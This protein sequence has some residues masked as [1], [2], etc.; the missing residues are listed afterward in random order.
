MVPGKP[1]ESLLVEM[2]SGDIPAMPHKEKRSDKR[3]GG[4]HPQMDRDRR[5]W[6]TELSLRDRRFEG[7][8]WWA[9]E[10]L[11]APKP[12]AMRSAWV[13]NP[14]DAFILAELEEHGLKPSLEADRRTL[15]RRLS[16]DL[17]GLPPTPEEVDAIPERLE[18]R[19]L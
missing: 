10:P 5:P 15:I 1:E 13:R 9:F 18:R 12:P 11:G 19:R 8:G 14:I 7:Q 4:G 2:I 3:R 17:I 16:F 6:P